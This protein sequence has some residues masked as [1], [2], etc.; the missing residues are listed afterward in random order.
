MTSAERTIKR[1]Q[2]KII[3]TVYIYGLCCP[4][5]NKI[6]YIGKTSMSLKRRLGLHINKC[7]KDNSKKGAWIFELLKTSNRPNI[8]LLETTNSNLASHKE[9][10]WILNIGMNNLYNGNNGGGGNNC[11][12]L[13][14]NNSYIARFNGFLKDSKYSKNSK[15][16]YYCY[17]VKFITHFKNN[18]ATPKEINSAQIHD[19]INLIKSKN[20]RNAHVVA[21]KVFYK[22][23]MNQ[24]YKLKNIHY[25][26][27]RTHQ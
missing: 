18:I 27:S 9:R 22:E 17:L 2:K 20:T 1:K 23:I 19:Y 7:S 15:R 3:S 24:P 13:N 25:E 11:D 10:Q 21:L 5:D 16:N 12:G 6:K 4:F 14:R 26:Y 8:I